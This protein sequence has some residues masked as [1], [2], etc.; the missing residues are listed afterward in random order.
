MSTITTVR[1]PKLVELLEAARLGRNTLLT[2]SENISDP[3]SKKY[4]NLVGDWVAVPREDFQR[5]RAAL[6]RYEL[7]G[8]M[9]A[10]I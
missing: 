6:Q 3:S 5:L 7:G 10:G 4:K 1:S 2:D 8:E 9:D